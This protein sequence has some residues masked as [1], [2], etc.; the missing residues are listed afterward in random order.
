MVETNNEEQD[1]QE[2][3]R[4]TAD[5]ADYQK[6]L[7]FRS[8]IWGKIKSRKLGK[9][10]AILIVAAA[11]VAGSYW[12]YKHKKTTDQPSEPVATSQSSAANFKIS[13]K[14][15]RYES[16]NFKLSFD[17]PT[18]WTAGKDNSDEISVLSPDL[19]L[20][21]TEGKDVVGQ[22]YFRIRAKGQPLTGFEDGEA[23]AVLD[24]QK[25]AY[26]SPSLV[27]R[28]S[29]YIS[30]LRYAK[31]TMGLDAIYITGDSGYKQGQ[32]ITQ[33]DIQKVDPIVSI[34]FYVCPD[35]G[36]ENI[37]GVSGISEEI[38]NNKNIATPLTNMLQSLIIN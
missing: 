20:K 31:N 7:K 11:L 37:S 26:A 27:Q 25:I 6:P 36:C 16:V 18:D 38:W 14:T 3:E 22:I 29:T 24:S 30:F 15:K 19:R 8:P 1:H 10:I 21:N 35:A 4:S 9:R 17:Y 23:K 12:F 13:A 32:S 2:P 34:E 28:A 5:Y 33:A